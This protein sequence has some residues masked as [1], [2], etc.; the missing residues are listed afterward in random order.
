MHMCLGDLM[1][2]VYVQVPTEARERERGHKKQTQKAIHR[3]QKGISGVLSI[4]LS[5]FPWSR[6]LPWTSVVGL[7][8]AGFSCP[9][10]CP[11]QSCIYRHVWGFW[12][13]MWAL[14]SELRSPN[15]TASAFNCLSSPYHGPQLYR[16]RQFIEKSWCNSIWQRIKEETRGETA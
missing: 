1:C 15:C 3:G 13:V 2:T 4:T 6:I 11:S 9:P 16:L 10:I 7:K 8:P 5:P 12:L 14:A